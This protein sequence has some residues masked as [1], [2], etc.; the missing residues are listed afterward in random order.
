MG[1]LFASLSVLCSLAIAH[2]LK[3]VRKD[4]LRLIQ[5][6]GINYL[7]AS[8]ISFFSNPGTI[9]SFNELGVI[10]FAAFA[11]GAIF[12]ANLFVYS[13]S[14]HQIGMGISIAA[15]RMSLIIPIGLSLWFFGEKVEVSTYSGILFVFIA[16][17]LTISEIFP[18]SA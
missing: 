6:L 11:V 7:I 2:L 13:A 9:P 18:R 16:F 15:M 17:F 1:L 4:N 3:I 14:I 8:I 12:I 10:P 5:V